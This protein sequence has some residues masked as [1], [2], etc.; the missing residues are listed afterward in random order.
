MA[1]LDPV[2]SHHL[3]LSRFPHSLAPVAR[4][5]VEHFRFPLSRFSHAA[6]FTPIA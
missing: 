6:A 4:D 5:S 3:P 2:H 1:V